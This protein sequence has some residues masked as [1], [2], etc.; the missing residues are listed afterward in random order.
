MLL[1]PYNHRTRYNLVAM[2]NA[3]GDWLKKNRK[4]LGLLQSDVAKRAGVSV[5]YIST[6]ERGQKHSITDAKLTPERHKVIAI[7]KAV[8]GDPSE[9]LGLYGYLPLSMSSGK[10]QTLGELI[11]I[12]E[13]LGVENIHFANEDAMKHATPDDLQAALDAVKLALEIT[14]NR[15]RPNAPTNDDSLMRP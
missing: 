13:T 6:L 2:E 10:P 12:L 14:I 3:A 8:Q 4:K 15:K 9:L 7:A 5:S 11:D 1:Q